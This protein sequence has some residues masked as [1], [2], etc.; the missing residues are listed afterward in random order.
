MNQV[1]VMNGHGNGNGNAA[2]TSGADTNGQALAANV[3]I[4]IGRKKYR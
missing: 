3:Q 4:K 1:A 2:G